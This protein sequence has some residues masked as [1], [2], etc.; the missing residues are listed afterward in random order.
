KI[1]RAMQHQPALLLG[2]FDLYETHG[3][4]PR[5]LADRLSV[6]RIVLVALDVGLH[7]LRRHQ[8]HPVAKFREFTRP[9]MSRGAGFHADKASRQ[10]LEE[11]QH[12]A[13]PQ[14][15]TN[16]DLFS[17][18]DAMDLQHVLGDIQTDRGNLHVD[19]SLIPKAR[20]QVSRGPSRVFPIDGLD[21]FASTS[22]TPL[23]SIFA[24]TQTYSAVARLLT[25]LPQAQALD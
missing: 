23:Q 11:L 22:S 8:P 21:R 18:V 17:R 14:L 19:S 7:V 3:R 1:A 5:R 9:I 24:Q 20:A 12:L 25:P 4:P 6:G 13:A 10:R 15:L 16:D 2:R